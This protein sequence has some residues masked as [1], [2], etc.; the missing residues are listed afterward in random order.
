[1]SILKRI[2]FILESNLNAIV[3]KGED[4]EK[5]IDQ[6]IRQASMDLDEVKKETAGIMAEESRTKR[7]LDEVLEKKENCIE[8]AKKAIA[9]GNDDDAKVFLNKKN[10]LEKDEHKKKLAYDLAK[11]NASKMRQLHD[12]LVED[13]STLHFKRDEIKSKKSLTKSQVKTY[14]LGKNTSL[15]GMAGKFNRLEKKIDYMLDVAKAQEELNFLSIDE[16]DELDELEKK[17]TQEDIN[18]DVELEALKR[19]LGLK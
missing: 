14:E 11:E 1:M 2:S 16:I 8:L 6:Y 13:I 17:Y 4:P 15:E 5:L 18:I 10:S 9:M 19:S 7:E 3:D 12:K